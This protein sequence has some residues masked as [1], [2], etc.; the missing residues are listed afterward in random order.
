[1][2]CDCG[3]AVRAGHGPERSTVGRVEAIGMPI[4]WLAAGCRV[5]ADDGGDPHRLGFRRLWRAPA[6]AWE[7][8]AAPA[9]R[10][11]EHLAHGERADPSEGGSG[12]F[13]RFLPVLGSTATSVIVPPAACP[14]WNAESRRPMTSAVGTRTLALLFADASEVTGGRAAE[15]G[16][17]SVNARRQPSSR[18]RRRIIRRATD[19]A[20]GAGSWRW[21][22]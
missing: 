19:L 7:S 16:Q 5:E 13:H 1:L 10:G 12:A 22:C 8:L 4:R 17:C 15:S 11:R 18:R 14:S 9:G 3:G 21:T 20:S 2:G 6:S